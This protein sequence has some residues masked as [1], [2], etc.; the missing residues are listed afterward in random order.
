MT[1]RAC[2]ALALGVLTLA[3]VAAPAD[4]KLKVPSPGKAVGALVHQTKALPRAAAPKARKRKLVRLAVS[5]KR[6][7]KRRPCRSLRRL[8]RYRRVIG[9]SKV[10]K[11]VA[12]LGAKS[13]DASRAL[14][15]T[16]RTR[17]CGGGLKPST[18]DT[19]KFTVLKSDANGMRLRVQLPALRFVPAQGGGRAWTELVLHDSDAF[20]DV[21]APGIPVVGDVFGVA[22]GA[23]VELDAGTA[24][25]Y[26]IQGVDVF[27]TQ[28]D[29]VDQGPLLPD[30][31][32]PQYRNTGFKIDRDAYDDR[33]KVPAQPVDGQMLGRSRDIVLGNVV[34]PAARYDAA[35]KTLEVLNSVDVTISFDGG[36]HQFSEQLDSPWERPQRSLRDGLLNA[37]VVRS[38]RPIFLERCGEEMLVITNPATLAAANQFANAKRAQGMRTSVVQIGSGSGQIGTTPAQIQSFIRGRLTAAGCIHPS[39]VTIMGDDELVPTFPGIGG[40]ESDL[41]YSLR[42]DADEMADVALGRIVGDDAAGVTNAVTKIVNYE[43]APPGGPWLQHATIAAEFQDD[44][45]PDQAEDRLFIRFAE[46]SRNGILDAGFSSPQQVDRIYATYPIG[47][48]DPLRY[49]DGT[50]LPP[51]LLK[52][53]FAWDGDTADISAAWNDGRYLMMHRNH[54]GTHG[55]DNPRFT[56]EDVEALTNGA[57]LPVVLSINCS[58][59]AFQDDDRSFATQ[60]LVNPNGGA[61]GVFGETEVSP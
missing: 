33:G 12:A 5:A 25:S 21:G 6:A 15:A 32:A 58:S 18:R 29:P 45:S 44:E 36:A 34:V 61:A 59:G 23:K 55:W 7:A 9:R 41:E 46:V 39:Y 4:A 48:V 47:A 3:L 49:R 10:R 31:N 60:A 54:G 30:R 16:K 57:M 51:E 17:R 11:G 43:N 50:P 20:G 24:S 26:T 28:P 37:G 42:D 38:D 8:A 19:P 13:M 14:L 52:P 53:A 22:D 35:R 56:S 2:R 40:I 27:P 1:G